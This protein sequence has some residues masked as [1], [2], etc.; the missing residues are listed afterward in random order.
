MATSNWISPG[1]TTSELDTRIA[2]ATGNDLTVA[3]EKLLI[4]QAITAAG[5]AAC[6]WNGE[7]WWW[8]QARGTFCCNRPSIEE[9]ASDG[10]TRSSNVATVTTTAV[11]G[12]VEGQFVLVTCS[13]DATFNG[14][15]RVT[16][17][18][19]TTTFTYWNKGD[20]V[21]AATS[22]DGT[23]SVV[24]YPLRLVDVAGKY[25]AAADPTKRVVP[26]LYAI[27]KVTLN[28]DY[29]LTLSFDRVDL[30]EYVTVYDSE[31]QPRE[32]A[33]SD[34]QITVSSTMTNERCLFLLPPPDNANDLLHISYLRQHSKIDTA[35]A[36]TST[37][38]ALLVPA[39][40]QWGV[41]IAGATWLIR[42]E[43]LNPDA[44]RGCPEFAATMGRMASADPSHDY[45]D[46]GF[47][48]FP[49]DARITV[50]PTDGTDS[51]YGI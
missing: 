35:S 24:S 46:G 15:F 39:E 1:L 5:Q 51:D 29:N 47:Y 41:Y 11:H 28:D 26:D 2:K 32:Y 8:Q 7:G 20:D 25:T 45:D 19:S 18:A 13:D 36:T 30:N 27:Q 42:N 22:G 34:E 17:A 9:A 12:I 40:F 21:S 37:T 4:E 16:A 50:F 6:T 10:V 3:A 23:V 33:I 48:T 31:G 14:V 38:A 44:L 49:A 43:T